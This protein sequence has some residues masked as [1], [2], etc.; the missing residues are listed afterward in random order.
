MLGNNTVVQVAVKWK[1]PYGHIEE[2]RSVQ[3]RHGR[4]FYV[5]G[6]LKNA[7]CGHNMRKGSL[8]HE[9][10]NVPSGHDLT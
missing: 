2:E 5:A 4:T 1:C 7:P 8:R 6:I 3:Q 9:V 10:E